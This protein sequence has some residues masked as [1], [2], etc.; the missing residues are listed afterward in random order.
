M[1]TLLFFKLHNFHLRP[2]SRNIDSTLQA[3][4]ETHVKF[5]LNQKQK[6][7][8]LYH[9]YFEIITNLMQW[10]LD[11]QTE[12]ELSPDNAFIRFSQEISMGIQNERTKNEQRIKR[13]SDKDLRR[14]HSNSTSVWFIETDWSSTVDFE[15]L[16]KSFCFKF[17]RWRCIM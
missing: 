17:A 13:L 15:V 8:E 10:Q 4:K 16:L 12:P 3:R 5:Q 1:R 7:S 9:R 11:K 14:G 6:P 2:K